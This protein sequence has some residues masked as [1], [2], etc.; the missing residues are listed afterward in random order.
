MKKTMSRITRIIWMENIKETLLRIFKFVS[1]I[2]CVLLFA[3]IQI[4]LFGWLMTYSSDRNWSLW[5][6]NRAGILIQLLCMFA[7]YYVFMHFVLRRRQMKPGV[8]CLISFIDTMMCFPLICI[9]SSGFFYL[10]ISSPNESLLITKD[11]IALG[12]ELLLILCHVS[13]AFFNR[14]H[15]F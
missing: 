14:N 4:L 13:L 9:A 3:Y 2:I 10:H 5:W 6:E 15:F 1:P 7:I 8:F 11:V 12:F